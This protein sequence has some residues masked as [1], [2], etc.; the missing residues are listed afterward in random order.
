MTILAI[1]VGN[2]QIV[3]GCIEDTDRVQTV[4][5]A[6]N[7]LKTDFEYAMDISNALVSFKASP[8]SVDGA[9]ISSVVPQLTNTL[10]QAVQIATDIVPI[11]VSSGIKTGL[12]I[13]IDD[14]ATAGSDLVATAVGAL[15]RYDPP[16]CIIDMGTATTISVLDKNGAFVG[17][18]ICP[19]VMLGMTALNVGTSL[20]PNISFDAPTKAIG[21]NTVDCIRSGCV[22]GAAAMLDGMLDR[23]EEELGY[24]VSVAATGGIARS[25]IPLCKREIVIDDDLLFYGLSVIFQRNTL[26]S[27]GFFRKN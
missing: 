7:K 23:I 11:I 5:I 1:D 13:L 2:S 14:P 24:P 19:G 3:L 4:R 26:A 27:K 22:T 15:N 6:T 21:K 20:L 12:N 25:V 8:D 9:I 17:G 16:I 18:S 10:A